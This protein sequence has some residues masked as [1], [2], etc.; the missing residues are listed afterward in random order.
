MK[1]SEEI[2][3]AFL[4]FFESKAHKVVKSAPIVLKDDPSLMFVNAGMNPFKDIFLNTQK[5]KYPRVTNTQKCLRVSG[6]HND[7]EEVGVDGYHH[8]LFE[9]LGNWSF[10]D[11]FKKESIDWAWE[12]LTKV[13]NID[14][15][16]LYVTVFKGDQNDGTGLDTQ[17][18]ELWKNHVQANRILAFDK[19]DNF[20]EMGESGPCGPCSEIHIDLRS[21]AQRNQIDGATLVNKDHE[22]V[23]E[24]WNLVFIEF[25]RLKSGKLAELPN[26]HIDT[27][28]GFE[29]LVRVLQNKSSNYDTDIFMPIIRAIE[30]IAS[31]SYGSDPQK[32]IAFRVI[33]DHVRAVSFS[34]ADGQL[35]SNTSAGYV[36]RRILRRAIRY[37]YSYLNIKRPF[38]FSLVNILCNQFKDV[39]TELQDQKELI[40]RVIE[41]EET[42]FLVTLEKGVMHFDQSISRHKQTS[43]I[44]GEEAFLLY[45]TYGFPIDLTQLMAKENG[46]K[47][48]LDGFAKALE[49]QKQRSKAA[50]KVVEG[51]W[52]ILDAQTQSA[53]VGYQNLELNARLLR[54]REVEAKEQKQYHLVYDKTPFYATSGGQIGDKGII[55]DKEN[56]LSIVDTIKENGLILHISN[57][58]PS[59]LSTQAHTLKVDNAS[60]HLLKKNHSAT[61]L[62]HLALRE[63]LGTHVT[64]KGSLVSHEYLRFDFSHFSKLSTQEI[65]QIEQ[66]VNQLILR[67]TALCVHQNMSIDEAKK[68]GAMALFG[69]KYGDKVRVVQFGESIE[70]CGGTHVENTAEIGGF[71]IVSESAVAAGIRRIEAATSFGILD[72]YSK[73]SQEFDHVKKVLKTK[74][75]SSAIETLLAEKKALEQKLEGFYKQQ[76][77]QIQSQLTDSKTQV[78]GIDLICQKVEIPK[79]QAK[80]LVFDL[81][82][83][84]N[85][86]VLLA[87]EDKQKPSFFI[88]FSDDLIQ[89]KQ[90]N[91]SELVKNLSEFIKGSGGGAPGFASA[92]GAN[93]NGLAEVIKVFQSG[94]W[95]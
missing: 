26:K 85:T 51:E 68:M 45:D 33:A 17:A 24:I 79:K 32:D 11:Y 95:I 54:Y 37:A 38:I 88:G 65:S 90:H 42:Q 28:M 66:R 47:V 13:Y 57:Q 8:T 43:I 19:K 87:L 52:V 59:H 18:V 71:K 53:F 41:Q 84:S 63:I 82:K 12:L 36:I 16:R 91:A 35:P 22:Q 5:P 74:K 34:I 78:Q 50:S 70:L 31:C 3:E 83:A 60:R 20:W 75:V 1:T 55:S 46:F 72:R 23:I 10:G 21:N 27:G 64:Q 58:D 94:T 40:Q 4:N 62:L 77:T 25:E 61:H 69:E 67:G 56:T 86:A 89:E 6:K 49:K 39:F 14:S 7:I 15:D 9:M 93:L 80:Q 30:G 76:L 29:R 2:R 48:D 73:I 44:P 92:G 81:K